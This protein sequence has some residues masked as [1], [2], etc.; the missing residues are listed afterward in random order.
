MASPA[1]AEAVAVAQANGNPNINGLADA[2]ASQPQSQSQSQPPSHPDAS[3]AS[4]PTTKRKREDSD[5]GVQS[6]KS[7]FSDDQPLRDEKKLIR[8]Y[9]Q[10]LQRYAR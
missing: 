10:V 2:D 1:G 5:D 7:L 3:Q 4:G 9:F 6:L 8:N